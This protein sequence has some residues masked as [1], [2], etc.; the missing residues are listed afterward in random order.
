MAFTDDGN[1]QTELM[2]DKELSQIGSIVRSKE[3][4]I[5]TSHTRL[6]GD[7]IGSLLAFGKV[8]KNLK[9]DVILAVDGEIPR[10][11]QFAPGVPE[12]RTM[13][14]RVE[15]RADVLVVLDSTDLARTGLK[16]PRLSPASTIINIDH[17]PDNTFFG[18]VNLV[19]ES[20]SSTCELVFSLIKANGWSLDEEIA[21]N[22]FIG[23]YT[24][25]G[26][27][28]YSNTTP[29][30]LRIAAELLEKKLPLAE[31]GK[32]IYQSL[33]PGILK[34]RA[35]TTLGIKTDRSG[36]IAWS[37]INRK[38]FSQTNTKAIDTQEFAN[39]PLQ[40][41]DVEVSVL[42][43]EYA[44]RKRVK[45]SLRSKGAVDVGA[46]ARE[47]GGG[48]HSRAAGLVLNDGLQQSKKKIV[49][50]LREVLKER[51]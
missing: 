28:L 23:I 5:V 7:G 14:K 9:K 3:K 46:V 2:P 21:E 4:F 47:F 16:F 15:D 44:D 33:E 25:T 43:I 27:F 20:A 40:L 41:K 37:V 6:D 8:L 17:H 50:R 1:F 13:Q 49:K 19:D 11:Y 31:I 22:I 26:R 10:I 18:T 34:L 32:N 12:I 38:M 45:A 30:S 42:F 24:D 51:P 39:I 48:G 35:K 29:E 36:R